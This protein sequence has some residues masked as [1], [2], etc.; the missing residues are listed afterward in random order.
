MGLSQNKTTLPKPPVAVKFSTPWIG[1]GSSPKTV[2]VPDE[3]VYSK[4]TPNGSPKYE[5][6][7]YNETVTSAE[8]CVSDS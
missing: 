1:G 3:L 8:Y 5:E 4:A 6:D 2:I 7:S